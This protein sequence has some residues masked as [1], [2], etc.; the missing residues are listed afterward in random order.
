MRVRKSNWGCDL[1]FNNYLIFLERLA[2]D[3]NVNWTSPTSRQQRR[4]VNV[5]TGNIN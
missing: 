1:F 5:R 4:P 2:V 3:L